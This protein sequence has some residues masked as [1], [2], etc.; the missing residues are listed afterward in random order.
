MK[1]KHILSTALSAVLAL[2]L[3]AGC[4]NSAS[5]SSQGGQ[6]EQ[7]EKTSENSK[8]L[9]TLRLAVMTGNLDHYASYV[10]VEQGI[11][12]KYGIDLQI[13]EYAYGINTI[14]AVVNGNADV[15][16]MADYAA[17]NRLGTTLHNTNLKL[18]SELNGGGV[19][20][21][22]LYVAPKYKDNL[23]ALDGSEGFIT[24]IG[25]VNEYL[26]SEAISYLGLD[27]SKQKIINTDSAQSALALAQKDGAASATIA[28]GSNA[29]YFE[30]Y[31][32]VLAVT[33]DEL[34]QD[35]GAYYLATDKFIDSN[36]ELLANYLTAINESY[37]YVNE[38]I[39]ESAEFLENK[40]GVKAEDFKLQWKVQGF[41][42]GFHEEAAEHLEEIQK[43]AYEHGKYDE[44]YNIRDFI[45]T[46]A[47]KIAFPNE[48]TVKT[49]QASKN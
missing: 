32:W 17:V 45:D 37:E 49:E 21:G 44:S 15:G 47:A 13:T 41:K 33:A 42:T 34:K 2:S 8:P 46:R 29:K 38:H 4:G 43:W 27:E 12:Q 22:G 30:K 5:Q 3:L 19:R 9:Q 20:D 18:F 14:D 24:Q 11:F 7:T 31:G 39:D 48:V 10:G 40:I 23:K 25:T 35:I 1:I 6:S 26:L 28:S 16:D 36:T